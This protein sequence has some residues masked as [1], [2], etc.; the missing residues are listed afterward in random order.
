MNEFELIERHFG[1]AA[2]ARED[3]TLGVGDD[4]A[5][6]RLPAG[7]ALVAAQVTLA[8]DAAAP[9]SLAARLVERALARVACRGAT[10]RWATLAL[11]LPEADERWLRHFADAL[12]A[13]LDAHGIALVGGDTT[14]GGFTATLGVSGSGSALR[15]TAPA[16]DQAQLLL[17]DTDAATCLRLG[18]ARAGT[19]AVTVRACDG[20]PAAAAVRL[21][22]GLGLVAQLDADAPARAGDAALL[23]AVPPGWSAPALE[24]VGLRAIGGLQRAPGT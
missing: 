1:R 6:L 20:D 3:I 24:G 19:P 14:R 5:L 22:R 17:A 16:L 10:P 12:A 9:E 18:R 21:G 23:L 2:P 13:A 11:T 7:D 15:E 4:G 8:V